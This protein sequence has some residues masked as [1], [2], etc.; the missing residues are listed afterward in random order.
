[1]GALERQD[2]GSIVTYDV[3]NVKRDAPTPYRRKLHSIS[4]GKKAG[5]PFEGL[6]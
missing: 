2:H 4:D 6:T 1:M 5:T 3:I